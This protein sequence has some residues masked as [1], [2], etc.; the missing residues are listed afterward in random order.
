MATQ[1]SNEIEDPS[2]KKKTIY[3]F[4]RKT[5]GIVEPRQQQR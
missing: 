2:K 4:E 5:K 3:I 1:A